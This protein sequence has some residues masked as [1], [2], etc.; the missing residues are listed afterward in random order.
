M[1]LQPFIENAI[2]HGLRYKKMKGFLS[3]RFFIKDNSLICRI[4]DNGVGRK[5]T[6]KIQSK[7]NK[8]YQS[9]GLKITAERLLT[10][11]KINDANIEFSINDKIQNPSDVNEEVGTIVEIR[12][13][14]N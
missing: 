6:E 5:N 10:Y 7:T 9:Q 1:I 2:N 11:N 13:P 4:E 8:G 3:I 14:E 12:F